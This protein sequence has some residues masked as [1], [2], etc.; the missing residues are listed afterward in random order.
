MENEQKLHPALWALYNFGSAVFFGNTILIY[1]LAW[2]STEKKADLPFFTLTLALATL[3]AAITMPIAGYFCDRMRK[4]APF[5]A[6]A[7][8]GYIS[9]AAGLSLFNSG[10]MILV[11][12]FLAAFFY[13]LSGVAYHALL[14]RV[15]TTRTLYLVSGYGIFCGYLGLITGIAALHFVAA[16]QGYKAVFLPAAFASLLFVLPA[17]LLIR[18]RPA[19][20]VP[21]G[22]LNLKAVASEIKNSWKKIRRDTYLRN[23]IAISSLGV[24]GLTPLVLFGAAY[25]TG[26]MRLSSDQTVRLFM[27]AGLSSAT[28]AFFSSRICRTF[29][30]PYLALSFLLK[31]SFLVV[32]FIALSPHPAMFQALALAGAFVLG[33]ALPLV[34]S[35]FIQ[36]S[37]LNRLSEYFG[38]LGLVTRIAGLS[39]IVLWGIITEL[40]DF[41]GAGRL[42]LAVLCTLIALAFALSRFRRLRNL[43]YESVI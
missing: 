40:F 12:F 43:Q 10:F 20:L 34:R 3:A 11:M 13:Q 9:G 30:S 33:A 16:R 14:A 38:F 23:F 35:L 4:R 41:A 24:A 25:A 29:Q 15:A 8:L 27:F 18:D 36:L 21:F 19:P 32:L 6:L 7:T 26:A 42:R 2:L 5:L 39:G 31:V 17:L 22:E 1:F 28:G 37:N